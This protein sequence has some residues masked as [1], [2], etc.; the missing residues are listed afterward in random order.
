MWGE[1]VDAYGEAAGG[2]DRGV[3]SFVCLLWMYAWGQE[4]SVAH[5]ICGWER[6]TRE[7]VLS[8]QRV[9]ESK[10]PVRAVV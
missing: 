2:V 1:D 10:P 5:G 8:N 9:S 4:H 7:S 6:Y 3:I